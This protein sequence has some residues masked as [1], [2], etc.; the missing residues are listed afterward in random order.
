M[1][2]PVPGHEV[3]V[4]D[5]EGRVLPAGETGEIAVRRPDPAMFLGYWNK[6]EKTAAKFTGDWLRT[7]DL[8]ARGCATAT[9]A[10]SAA[11]TTS[12]PRPAT[13]SARP[14]SR[15]ASTGHPDVVMAAAVGVPDPVRTEVV[16]A[17]VVLREG[18]ALAGAGG[19][20]DRPGPRPQVSPHVAPRRDRRA[21]SLPM[22]ATGKIMRRELRAAG[23]GEARARPCKIFGLD[24]T[25]PRVPHSDRDSGADAGD[26][27]ER[28]GT[29]DGTAGPPITP[30]GIA[31]SGLRWNSEPSMRRG[32][33]AVLPS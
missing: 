28:L 21:E 30:S 33:R 19:G 15:T 20:A 1:G 18:V 5:A 25:D 29:A 6:P 2:Q 26:R 17:F 24:H 14:R 10:T 22:T 11:T 13:G 4:I 9:S 16:K 12:S 27:R 3:A 32:C 31:G 7:G 23:V 8:G